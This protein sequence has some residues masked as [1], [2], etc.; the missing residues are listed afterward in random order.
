MNKNIRQSRNLFIYIILTIKS[1][2]MKLQS[3]KLYAAL[4]VLMVIVG[5]FSVTT[6]ISSLTKSV[7]IG[8]TG[9]IGPAANVTANSGSAKDIQA[10][11]DEVAA[12]GGGEVHV[13]EGE[14]NFV[15]VGEPWQTVDIPAG[16]S[17]FG[18][19][20]ERDANGQVIEWKT[21]LVMPYDVPPLGWVYEVWWFSITGDKTISSRFSDIRLV[22]YRSIDPDSKSMIKGILVDGVKD[23]RIDHVCLEHTC[24]G[25][26]TIWRSCGVVDHCKLFNIYGNDDLANYFNGNLGYGI[27]VQYDWVVS[28]EPTMSVLGQYTSY[29]TYIEDCYLSRWRHC[30]SAGHGAHYV[31]RYNTINK[32]P[33]HFSLD[34]HGLRDDPATL[35][36]SGGTRCAEFYENHLINAVSE[37]EVGEDIRAVLQNGGGCGVWFNNYIDDTYKP[38]TMQLYPEDYYASEVWHLKDFYLWSKLGAWTTIPDGVPSGFTAD[39]NVLADWTRPAGNSTDPNYPNVDP[40]WS[41]AGYHPYPYPHPLTL[42]G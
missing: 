20:T 26:I 11:V 32:D 27:E 3:T 13:P 39:R 10:A 1:A 33:G 30:V 25:G 23:F 2:A 24:A 4:F 29:S 37:P 14:F 9:R 21:I 12:A 8:S 19:P 16:V 36:N 17:L 41:I 34:V 7:I 40:A 6:A 5:T 31:F 22:G 38:G 35:P 42:P 18:A 28:F 15:E